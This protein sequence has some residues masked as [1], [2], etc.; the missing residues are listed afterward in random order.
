MWTQIAGPDA[1][2]LRIQVA[3]QRVF[4]GYEMGGLNISHPQQVCEG[5]MLNT[6][7]RLIQK[8]REHSEAPEAAPNIVRILA[9]LVA[10]T[11]CMELHKVLQH[12]GAQAWRH[13][14]ARINAHSRKFLLLIAL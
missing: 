14:A 2:Q 12:G 4:V 11:G 8:E 1:K 9:G 13:A 10:H 5:L 6:L 7:E 3:F